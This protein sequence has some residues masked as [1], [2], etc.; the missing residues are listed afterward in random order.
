MSVEVIKSREHISRKKRPDDGIHYI[1]EWICYGCY[2]GEVKLSFSEWRS[3]AKIKNNPDRHFIMPGELYTRQ[4]N[5]M[6]GITY[7]FCMKTDLFKIAC[8]LDLFVE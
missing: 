8:K 3:I 6:D 7:N 5:K 4:F 1:M 2:T